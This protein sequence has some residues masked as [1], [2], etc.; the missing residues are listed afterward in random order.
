[1]PIH[2][3]NLLFGLPSKPSVLFPRLNE[4]SIGSIRGVNS[5]IPVHMA[6]N[7][8]SVVISDFSA[9]G[10]YDHSIE[11]KVT[12]L[13]VNFIF[14]S[15]NL[16]KMV[17]RSPLAEPMLYPLAKYSAFDSASFVFPTPW[18]TMY[19]GMLNFM[20][21]L[22]SVTLSACGR[23]DRGSYPEAGTHLDSFHREQGKSKITS[24]NVAGDNA[25]MFKSVAF[26]ASPSLRTFTAKFSKGRGNHRGDD[27]VYVAPIILHRL[28]RNA[29][30]IRSVS[31][32]RD[33]PEL[34]LDTEDRVA[35]FESRRAALIPQ[36]LVQDLAKLRN[37][38]ALSFKFIPFV[39]K[40]FTVQLVAGLPNLP[41]LQTLCLLPLP[42]SRHE[43]H[44]LTLPTLECLRTLSSTNLALQHL[45]ISIDMSTIPADT[46]DLLLP[47]HALE[48]LFIAP[49]YTPFKLSTSDLVTLSTFLDRL[50]PNLQDVTSFFEKS[51]SSRKPGLAE[52][53]VLAS[54]LW[55]DVERMVRSYQIL[56]ERVHDHLVQNLFVR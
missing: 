44:K 40:T 7:L 1:M 56:R 34:E 41:Q 22:K 42:L 24:L 38:T 25:F 3:F 27:G 16:S 37:L 51:H 6:S 45:T 21:E 9:A 47:G 4:L 55:A 54:P 5:I 20:T 28:S 8:R 12:A 31:F 35:W 49:F 52:A 15:P 14:N 43:R 2:W 11:E 10:K 53:S 36:N 29:T 13:V 26:L 46:P 32:E 19:I 50:F 30:H 18:Q 48:T 39:D 23:P 17:L 33:D